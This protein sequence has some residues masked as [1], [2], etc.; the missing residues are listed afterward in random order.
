[1]YKIDFERS[2]LQEVGTTLVDVY[3]LN[4][5]PFCVLGESCFKGPK[6]LL[7][8]YFYNWN[9]HY[10]LFCTKIRLW[11]NIVSDHGRLAHWILFIWIAFIAF[12]R[13]RYFKAP[14]APNIFTVQMFIFA[15]FVQKTNFD[16][17]QFQSISQFSVKFVY[18]N[19]IHCRHKAK[20]V[21]KL[22]KFR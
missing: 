22:Q 16:R 9:V 2:H 5:S 18:L 15:I 19:R 13:E 21:F 20:V 3:L 14:K 4:L 7:E 17:S 8:E 1:M 6:V 12:I 10:L 11:A